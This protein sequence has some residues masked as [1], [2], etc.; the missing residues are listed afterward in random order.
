M[1]VIYRVMSF[2]TL[3]TKAF[4]YASVTIATEKCTTISVISSIFE[5][6]FYV[7]HDK[8]ISSFMSLLQNTSD[9]LCVSHPET[10]TFSISYQACGAVISS[11]WMILKSISSEILKWL[12]QC[13]CVCKSI[14]RFP[15]SA[16]PTRI[17]FFV[18]GL[19]RSKRVPKLFSVESS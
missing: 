8:Y 16:R 6:A 1:T 15:L 5:K 19:F 2:G 4:G 9:C 11:I 13:V 12:K 14:H 10:I 17:R 3:R 7:I 18:I